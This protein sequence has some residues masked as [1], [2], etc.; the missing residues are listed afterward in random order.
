MTESKGTVITIRVTEDEKEILDEFSK[1]RGLSI[2]EYVRNKAFE[3]IDEGNDIKNNDNIKPSFVFNEK[4]SK[5]LARMIVD[6]Y[7]YTRL[8]GSKVADKEERDTI[9]EISFEVINELNIQKNKG[10]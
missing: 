1:S 9:D 4:Q 3:G 5:K 8:I 10:E 6:G 2:S 7:Y